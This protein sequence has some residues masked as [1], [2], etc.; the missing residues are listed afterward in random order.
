MITTLKT[1][2]DVWN[3]W[4]EMFPSNPNLRGANLRDADLDFANLCDADLRDADLHFANLREANLR[5]ANL[6]YANLRGAN[7]RDAD[8]RGANLRDA[9]LHYPNLRGANL[10]G[11]NLD[12]SCLDLS[13]K[14]LSTIFDE[15]Q[16]IQF[17][18]HVAMPTQNNS[19]N[20]QDKDL[21]KL[22]NMKTF[23]KV[24]NKFHKVEE[25]GTFTGTK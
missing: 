4:R 13:C 24:V 25:C 18:F 10:R 23:Q 6:H 21:K 11:A 7:L 2:V 15:K 14:T 17:L 20:I 19:L 12:F 8:L 9:D 16:L 5:D 3:I 22:L 1:K